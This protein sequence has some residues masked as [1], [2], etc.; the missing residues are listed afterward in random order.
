[1]KTREQLIEKLR[2][3]CWNEKNW[4]IAKIGSIN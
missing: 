1:M 4:N 3:Y 2:D